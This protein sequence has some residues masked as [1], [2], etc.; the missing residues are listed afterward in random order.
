MRPLTR[1]ASLSLTI[2]AERNKLAATM[3]P[4]AW[5]NFGHDSCPFVNC[6]A[7]SHAERGSAME[8]KSTSVKLSLVLHREHQGLEVSDLSGEGG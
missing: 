8:S 6:E 2:I 1:H 4:R 3:T 5:A 7:A